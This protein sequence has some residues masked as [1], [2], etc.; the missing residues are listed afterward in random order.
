MTRVGLSWLIQGK[1]ASSSAPE[2]G[3]LTEL[4]KK[5]ST[6]L[7]LRLS[8]NIGDRV[9]QTRRKTRFETGSNDVLDHYLKV[10]GHITNTYIDDNQ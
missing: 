1:F 2:S 8:A 3:V 6:M 4:A 7:V 10:L 5:S 9:A